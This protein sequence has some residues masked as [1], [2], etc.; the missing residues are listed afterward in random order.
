MDTFTK[1][2]I[3]ILSI[4]GAA[5]VGLVIALLVSHKRWKWKFVVKE[6]VNGRKIR[7]N[8]KAREWVIDGITFLKV[9]KYAKF[10]AP[11]PPADA[12]ELDHRGKKTVE[13]Y[14]NLTGEWTY[15]M[16]RL[17]V[18]HDE[19]FKEAD[20]ED[21]G[22]WESIKSLFTGAEGV[23]CRPAEEKGFIEF[24]KTDKGY[25]K[26]DEYEA[27]KDKTTLFNSKKVPPVLEKIR[28]EYRTSKW[29]YLRELKGTVAPLEPLT[30]S[31]RSILVDQQ[32]KA[33]A[34]M[35]F[36]WK[37]HIG[38]IVFATAMLFI[39]VIGYLC[40]DTTLEHNGQTVDAI[41]A[42]AEKQGLFM[43]KIGL[44]L[45]DGT[46]VQIIKQQPTATGDAPN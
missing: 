43:E 10:P 45:D 9:K 18:V 4:F 44:M 15:T 14:F 20:L 5:I 17:A 30:T 13:A 6:V 21:P 42:N 28:Q 31:Q 39:L 19:D 24:V 16:D 11:M 35:G 33:N 29:L 22:F 1:V 7:R 36:N 37:E 25:M 41:A 26:A 34:D 40:Y 8:L 23:V 46:K 12:I 38:E 3:W 32:G 27:V 2:M